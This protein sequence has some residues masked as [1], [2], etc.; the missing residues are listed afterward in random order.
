MPNLTL[1]IKDFWLQGYKVGTVNIDL[2]RQG[3]R[4]NWHNM[5][6]NSGTSQVIVKGWWELVGE[7]SHSAFNVFVQGEDNTELME[8]FGINSGIQ[9]APFES[10]SDLAWQGAPWSI[11]VET[12]Q[13]NVEAKFGKGIISDVSGAARLLGMFSLDSIIRRMQLDFSDVFDKGMAFDSITGTGEIKQGIFV[14]NDLEMDAIA[15]DMLLRGSAD[16]SNRTVDA[17]VTFT[18]DLTSGLPV[19]TAFAVA[20]QTAWVVFAISTVISPV[21]EVFTKIRYQVKG[22]FDA[23]EVKELSRSQGDY[24]LPSD[25]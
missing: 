5:S 13:G 18:P 22:P 21:V 4:L 1:N 10:T 24:T 20:P 17:E 11:Q 6:F 2:Q 8:R 23:P 9:K 19:L 15:G 7:K 16:M 3:D 14:T 12:L 25:D